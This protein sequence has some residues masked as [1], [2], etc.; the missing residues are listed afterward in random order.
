MPRS[1]SN[2]YSMRYPIYNINGR[3][4]DFKNSFEYFLRIYNHYNSWNRIKWLVKSTFMVF[5]KEVNCENLRI[6]SRHVFLKSYSRPD[7]NLLFNTI[8]QSIDGEKEK[9]DF[10]Y[11][12]R[13]NVQALLLYFKEIKLFFVLLKQGGFFGVALYSQFIY[14]ISILKKVNRIETSYLTIFY[15][16]YPLENIIAQY[17]KQG[18]VKIISLQH[19]LFVEKEYPSPDALNYH[20]LISDFYLA[21][22][23]ETEELLKKYNPNLNVC[24]C[25]KPVIFGNTSKPSIG[26]NRIL[27]VI[28]GYDDQIEYNKILIDVGKEFCLQRNHDLNIRFHPKSDRRLYRDLLDKEMLINSEVSSIAIAHNTTALFELMALGCKVAKLFSNESS[29]KIKNK[30]ILFN[31]SRELS[32]TFSDLNEED[33]LEIS[34]YYIA[35]SFSHSIEKYREFYNCLQ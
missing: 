6:E 17:Y 11:R 15:E 10:K 4:I 18:G 20:G 5:L 33:F 31:N 30:A 26:K 34:K 25:G 28:L 35:H 21:W 29:N 12:Y 7:F 24:I 19:A 27:S 13:L 22:G 2:A 14:L 16:T 32:K 23:S 9:V 8:F 3:L 1:Q